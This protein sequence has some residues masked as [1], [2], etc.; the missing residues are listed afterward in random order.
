M[1]LP[2]LLNFDQIFDTADWEQAIVVA[3]FHV[4][5]KEFHPFFHY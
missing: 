4:Y 5:L 3:T 2:F 1:I